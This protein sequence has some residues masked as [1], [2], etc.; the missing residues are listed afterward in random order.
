MQGD[1]V[2][3]E[4]LPAYLSE[5][6]ANLRVLHDAENDLPDIAATAAQRTSNVAIL[7]RD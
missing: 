5:I 7:Q 4:H 1:V 3:Y 6:L 2:G